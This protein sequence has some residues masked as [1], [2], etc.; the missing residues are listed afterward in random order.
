M[1]GGGGEGER[2]LFPHV[3]LKGAD[4]SMEDYYLINEIWQ[5]KEILNFV[6][7]K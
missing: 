1:L 2:L 6:C 7:G 5:L 4:N 3:S